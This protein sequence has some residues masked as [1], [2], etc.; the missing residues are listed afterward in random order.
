MLSQYRNIER[1]LGD[2]DDWTAPGTH[3]EI[4]LRDL[5][6]QFLPGYYRADKG[7]IYGRL[8]FGE[9]SK[10]CPEID[11]LIH[12]AQNFRPV[13]QLEDF[14][15]VQA[16]AT[17]GAIQ[18]KRRMDTEQL[19]EGIDNAVEAREHF[20]W[21]CLGSPR[22]PSTRFFSAVL[23]FDEKSPRRDGRASGTYRNVITEKFADPERRPY[24]P[25]IIGS[26]QGYIFRRDGDDSSRL[27]YVGFPAVYE[28]RNIAVQVVLTAMNAAIGQAGG[29]LPFPGLRL[30]QEVVEVIELVEPT[31]APP[32]GPVSPPEQP[33][34]EEEPTS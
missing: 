18:V 33:S 21:L 16:K 31:P 30:P 10:H 12:D 23:F 13:F 17:H 26:L 8:A 5:L 2:T 9:E 14:V 27:R 11:V 7:F 24:A 20:A 15:I 6:R 22:S 29:E 25:D 34:T 3:C 28:G 4:L 1:L 32:A 19:R